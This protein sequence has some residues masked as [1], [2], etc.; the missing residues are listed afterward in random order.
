MRF[1]HSLADAF[2]DTELSRVEI[3]D[4]VS[5]MACIHGELINDL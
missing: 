5:A 3:V 2:F 4:V 1:E